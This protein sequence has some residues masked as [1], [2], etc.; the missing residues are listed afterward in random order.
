MADRNPYETVEGGQPAVDSPPPETGS[1]KYQPPSLGPKVVLPGEWQRRAAC[2]G[3]LDLFSLPVGGRV[4]SKEV[5]CRIEQAKLVCAAC[6][7]L[8][9]CRQWAMTQPDPAYGMVAGGMDYFERGQAHRTRRLW[10][11][12]PSTGS[13]VAK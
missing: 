10:A 11:A 2:R 13:S 8:A 9:E 7:V 1:G 5:R 12:Q 6:P 4:Y 3:M